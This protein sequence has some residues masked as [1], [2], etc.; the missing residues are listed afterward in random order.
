[1][2]GP[3]TQRDRGGR[4]DRHVP[5]DLRGRSAVRAADLERDDRQRPLPLLAFAAA[6]A[7]TLAATIAALVARAVETALPCDLADCPAPRLSVDAA[8]ELERTGV[9]LGGYAA[10]ATLLSALYV[11]L[12]LVLGCLVA[13]RGRGRHRLLI[14]W[15]WIAMGFGSVSTFSP[16]PWA[17]Y[18][19]APLGLAGFFWL[20]ASFPTLVIAPRW[21]AIPA[22]VASAWAVVVFGIPPVAE[23]IEH[24]RAPWYQL[25]GPVFIVCVLALTIGQL[26]RWRT[27]DAEAR[28]AQGQLLVALGFMFVGGAI[29]AVLT[30]FP[31]TG[32]YGSLL[33]G[34]YALLGNF[35]S[36]LVFLVIA[37][38]TIRDGVYG[39]RV[40]LDN[41]LFGASAVAI[42]TATY[43]VVVAVASQLLVAAAAAGVAA[44]AVAIALAVL[45]LPIRRGI[46]RLVYGEQNAAAVVDAVTSAVARAATADAVIPDAL[47]ALR[48]RM[49]WPF[50]RLD[51]GELSVARGEEPARTAGAPLSETAGAPE[52]A[53]AAEG[54]TETGSVA[55][56][57]AAA[58][59][60]ATAARDATTDR[61][62]RDAP[63][64]LTVGL[65][66]GQRRLT[67]R[68]RS[69][70][71]ATSGAFRTAANVVVLARAA[72]AAR[73]EVVRT[74]E[75]ERAAL[76]RRLHDG[77]G[78]SLAVARHL[79][80]GVRADLG[81]DAAEQRPLTSADRALDDAIA[82]VRALSREL[83]PPTLD[84]LGF[85]RS[86]RVLAT[87][88][89]MDAEIVGDV[90]G[91]PPEHVVALYR[92]AAE[93]IVNA[94][95]H[96]AARSVDVRVDR[97]PGAL[98]MRVSDD[99]LGWDPTSPAG[100]GLAS[101]RERVAELDGELAVRAR[102]P[103]GTVVDIRVTVPEETS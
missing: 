69:I 85:A 99:G 76:R 56:P 16:W 19:I 53:A 88:L 25:V 89:G 66:E 6:A 78:P 41:V 10:L 100:V 12:L 26:V 17:T 87:D 84:D 42:A 38:A 77:V 95:R 51:I 34:V 83:R 61:A 68:D 21:V 15:V 24:Q 11:V 45:L 40:A 28:R 97:E 13:F 67:R 32:G 52:V 73:R 14:G 75:R 96:G 4:R 29:G 62:E 27:A 3:A 103:R 74:R 58:G 22:S 65:R 23:A 54:A 71:A 30:F 1:M 101:M 70:L 90:D 2:S 91:L 80:Q 47:D 48:T 93:S 82:Q 60:P 46:D 79:V 44:V 36:G 49:R 57:P 39:V 50:A 7:I 20:L 92:I 63:A 9:S 94:H 102:D 8:A 81:E 55:D 31:G 5:D 43:V 72:D 86:L 35:A 64:A 98:R 59:E 18:T 37:A 33:G